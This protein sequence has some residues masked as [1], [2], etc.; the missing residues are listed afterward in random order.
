MS[1]TPRTSSPCGVEVDGEAVRDKRKQLGHTISSFAPLA[2]IS[3][4]YLSQI[5]RGH[6]SS[7]SPPAFQ[8][9]AT[10]LGLADKPERIMRQRRRAVRA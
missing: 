9:L 8:R 5:E 1:G 3:V 4:G 6:R 2:Q 10:A 7:M